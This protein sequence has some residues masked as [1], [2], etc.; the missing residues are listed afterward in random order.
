MRIDDSGADCQ[1][2]SAAVG[3]TARLR[4]KQSFDPIGWDSSP[5]VPEVRRHC[6]IANFEPH[7]EFFR[8]VPRDGHCLNC[9]LDQIDNDLTQLDRIRDDIHWR[10]QEVLRDRNADFA[11]LKAEH[12]DCVRNQLLKIRA[13]RR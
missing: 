11:P 7:V 13:N 8:R 1:S 9:V 6:C 12:F 4:L 2:N 10:V 5:V 3:L